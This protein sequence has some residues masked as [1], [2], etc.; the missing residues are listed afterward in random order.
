MGSGVQT[1]ALAFSGGLAPGPYTSAT[2]LWNGTSWTSNPTGVATARGLGGGVGSQSL[3]LLAG[4]DTP[5]FTAATEEWTGPG[6]A[7][8]RT[9]TVS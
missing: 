3:A 7:E 5:G 6:F 1:A 4:G 8:T 2:E 9:V